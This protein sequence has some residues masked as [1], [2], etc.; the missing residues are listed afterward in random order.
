MYQVH[1]DFGHRCEISA[2]PSLRPQGGRSLQS[3]AADNREKMQGNLR[4]WLRNWRSRP[5][6]IAYST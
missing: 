1:S 3:M 4:V 2:T 5:P 6:Y